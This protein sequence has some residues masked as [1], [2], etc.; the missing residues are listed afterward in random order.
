VR[1][2]S[3]W[4]CDAKILTKSDVKDLTQSQ[5]PNQEIE[6]NH[7]ANLADAQVISMHQ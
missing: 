5:L 7:S 6:K 1:H 3:F 4:L 2:I